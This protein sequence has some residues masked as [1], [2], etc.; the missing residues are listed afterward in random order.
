MRPLPTIPSRLPQPDPRQR[1]LTSTFP[2]GLLR[3]SHWF[4]REFSPSLP[5]SLPQERLASFLLASQFDSSKDS[6]RSANPVRSRIPELLP[7]TST[8]SFPEWCLLVR[9][10]LSSIPLAGLETSPLLLPS[11]ILASPPRLQ[12]TLF[13]GSVYLFGIR[14]GIQSLSSQIRLLAS[15]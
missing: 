14:I 3:Q 2:E 8:D 13:Q 11:V 4:L 6:L 1:W 15:H 5:W 7:Q 10:P 9:N 12:L